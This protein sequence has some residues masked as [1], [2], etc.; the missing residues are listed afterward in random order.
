MDKETL[1]EGII[2]GSE[3]AFRYIYDKYYRKLCLHVKS[4]NKNLE[5]ESIVQDVIMSLWENRKKAHKIQDIDSYLFKSVYYSSLNVLKKERS[6]DEY[7][8]TAKDELQ[9]IQYD[10]LVAEQDEERIEA[11]MKAIDSLPKQCAKVLKMK[12]IDGYSSKEIASQLQLSERT[13]ETHVSNALK[14][15]RKSISKCIFLTALVFFCFLFHKS[16]LTNNF[17]V[18]NNS[19]S[20]LTLF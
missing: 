20:Q 18:K 13:V 19:E 5:C 7:K 4:I 9:Q 2:N 10:N 3:L 15:L 17:T 6:L 11:L 8:I 14:H 1:K 12:R 16:T